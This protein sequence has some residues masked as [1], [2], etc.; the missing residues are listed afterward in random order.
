MKLAYRYCQFYEIEYIGSAKCD[1]VSRKQVG[2]ALVQDI[3]N[4]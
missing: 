1:R 2:S 3:H 4:E